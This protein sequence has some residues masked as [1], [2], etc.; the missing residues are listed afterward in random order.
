MNFNIGAPLADY[1][2]IRDK[3]RRQ[4]FCGASDIYRI[5]D[6]FPSMLLCDGILLL[7]TNELL[8]R[9]VDKMKFVYAARL[10]SFFQVMS[11]YQNL[12][13]IKLRV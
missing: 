3:S 13:Y 10:G 9:S 6:L 12:H 8:I 4:P 2:V 5:I 1:E 7:A 11:A